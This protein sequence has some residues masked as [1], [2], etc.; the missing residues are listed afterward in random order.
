MFEAEDLLFEGKAGWLM[1]RPQL[2]NASGECLVWCSTIS[3]LHPCMRARTAHCQHRL[4]PNIATLNLP[5]HL[6]PKQKTG[7]RPKAGPR[8]ICLR[9][10]KCL[11]MCPG[12]LSP[13]T[14]LLTLLLPQ[15]IL[16]TDIWTHSAIQAGC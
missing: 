14:L 4:S 13:C 8:S 2:G 6:L 9:Q 3:P 1:Y 11:E 16:L 7:A 10:G 5:S 15:P 12:L